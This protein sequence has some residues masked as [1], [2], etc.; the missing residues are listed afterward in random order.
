[1]GI[2]VKDDVHPARL[3]RVSGW[4]IAGRDR[5]ITA[6]HVREIISYEISRY[7]HDLAEHPRVLH[8]DVH[9]PVS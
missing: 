5:R 4:I 1:M 7:R 2:L 3:G 9:R 8:R 6:K